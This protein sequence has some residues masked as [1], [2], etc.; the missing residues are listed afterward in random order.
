MGVMPISPP[1][2]TRPVG[3]MTELPF[4][5]ARHAGTPYAAVLVETVGLARVQR[6][7]HGGDPIH[8]PT[9]PRRREVRHGTATLLDIHAS[10]RG[11]CP[12]QHRASHCA[13]GGDTPRSLTWRR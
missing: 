2:R 8:A 4:R 6:V 11:T 7:L 5:I 9:P 13:S 1:R 12:R 10:R 3:R